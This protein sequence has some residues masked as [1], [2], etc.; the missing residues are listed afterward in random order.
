MGSWTAEPGAQCP[1]QCEST[2]PA[3]ETSWW[4][5]HPT[6]ASGDPAGPSVEPR[7]CHC[8]SA[9]PR[10][11]WWWQNQ[12]DN[13][14]SNSSLLQ[15]AATARRAGWTGRRPH[16]PHSTH[17]APWTR[18]PPGKWSINAMKC[19]ISSSTRFYNTHLFIP[20]MC[21]RPGDHYQ[22][23]DQCI[24]RK[25]LL[26]LFPAHVVILRG[27]FYLTQPTNKGGT[28]TQPRSACLVLLPDWK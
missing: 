19:C 13:S 7:Q 17:Y 27:C 15:S 6:K 2:E 5:N 23:P 20:V 16:R 18:K 1:P 26:V 12:P 4:P 28:G 3:S 10:H 21:T 24:Q 11:F 25:L 22:F 14:P 9:L 8:T